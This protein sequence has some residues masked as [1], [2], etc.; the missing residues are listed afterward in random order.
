M[1]LAHGD[2]ID[3]RVPVPIHRQSVYVDDLEDEDD[4]ELNRFG[5]HQPYEGQMVRNSY[6]GVERDA[7]DF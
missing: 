4:F 3:K 5:R 6:K 7:R 1:K 2:P